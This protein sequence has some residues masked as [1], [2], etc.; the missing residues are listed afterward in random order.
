MAAQWNATTLGLT[1][2]L[3][4]L[5]YPNN[6]PTVPQFPYVNIRSSEADHVNIDLSPEHVHYAWHSI[7]S[8]PAPIN[9]LTKLRDVSR[10]GQ[11]E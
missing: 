3:L 5:L 6:D 8:P 7:F 10:N 2:R 9:L 11:L 1:N 4:T